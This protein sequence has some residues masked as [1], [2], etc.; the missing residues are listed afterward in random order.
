MKLKISTTIPYISVS[1]SLSSPGVVMES[2]G[3]IKNSANA[4][5]QDP[6]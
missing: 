4:S 5:V 6:S 3:V 2:Q 1:P